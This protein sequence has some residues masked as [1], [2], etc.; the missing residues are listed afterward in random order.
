MI[1]ASPVL[2]AAWCYRCNRETPTKLLPLSSGHIGNLCADCHAGR[3]GRPF[4][5]VTQ[6]QQ[7]QADARKGR[8]L[9]YAN[10]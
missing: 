10:Q 7:F 1:A 9:H 4:A 5:T 8:G 6:Y 2:G 3:K